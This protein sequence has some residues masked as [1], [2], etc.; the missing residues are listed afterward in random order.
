MEHRLL[1]GV[2]AADGDGEVAAADA[3]G[4]AFD[5]A[6]ELRRQPGGHAEVVVAAVGHADAFVQRQAALAVIML[7]GGK[8]LGLHGERGEEIHARHGEWAGEALGQPAGEAEV[9]R[10]VVRADDPGDPP[11]GQHAVEQPLPGVAG[12]VVAEAGVEHR[13]ATVVLDKVD[14]H[15]VEQERQL[16]AHPEHARRDLHETAVGRRLCEGETDG[17]GGGLGQHAHTMGSAAPQHNARRRPP[18]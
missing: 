9:V 6:E 10:V 7:V 1:W 3:Q 12:L 8:A 14:I 16:E 5:E 15:V 4:L 13:P 11:P 2:A 17:G 18:A